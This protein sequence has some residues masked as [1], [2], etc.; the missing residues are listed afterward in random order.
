MRREEE[1]ETERYKTKGKE[2]DKILTARTG[3]QQLA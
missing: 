2:K 1:R 3:R